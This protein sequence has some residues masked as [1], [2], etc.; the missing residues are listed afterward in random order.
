MEMLKLKIPDLG[1]CL[2][3]IGY[4]KKREE[5]NKTFIVSTVLWS[6]VSLMV[7]TIGAPTISRKTSK[8]MQ[9]NFVY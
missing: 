8:Q 1:I 9:H 4:T 6:T 2:T 7:Q 3:H 5:I